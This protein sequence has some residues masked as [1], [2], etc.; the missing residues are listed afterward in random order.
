M[1]LFSVGFIFATEIAKAYRNYPDLMNTRLAGKTIIVEGDLASVNLNDDNDAGSF[2][3]QAA[4]NG[5]SLGFGLCNLNSGANALYEKYKSIEN[6]KIKVK[7][8]L[9]AQAPSD[10]DSSRSAFVLDNCTVQ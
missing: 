6:K 9:A 8:V 5:S 1:I 10:K 7:G 4:F 2:L 3:I